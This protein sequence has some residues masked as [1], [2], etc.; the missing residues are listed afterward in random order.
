MAIGLAIAPLFTA[1]H[2]PQSLLHAENILALSP[3]YWLL[4]DIL[5][6]TYEADG[7][8]QK[9]VTTAF[10]SIGLFIVAMWLG[11]YRCTWSVPG[12]VTRLVCQEFSGI[13]YF[14]LAATAFVLSMLTFAIPCNF[15][16]IT[17]FSYLGQSRWSA[18]WVRGQLGGMGAFVDQ[19]QYFGY[20]LPS[21]TVIV[22]QLMGWL[23]RRTLLSM[24]M[25]V[26]VMAFILQ[27]GS[28]R[29]IGM[30]MGMAL[31]IWI[32]RQKQVQPRHI[33]MGAVLA[34]SI[35]FSLELMLQYRTVGL[36]VLS[37]R[38]E[39]DPL[40]EGNSI[41]VDDNF[42]RMCQ[43]IELIP[44]HYS[45]TYEKYFIW[46]VVRPIPRILWPGKPIN[47]G[48]DL[49][50]VLGFKETS[51]T[52]SVIGELYMAAGLLGV[53]LGGWLYGRLAAMTTRLL[54]EGRTFGLLIIYGT[55]TMSL[56]NGMRSMVELILMNYSTVAWIFLSWLFL[57]F[58]RSAESSVP[59]TAE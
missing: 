59:E 58:R 31:V 43:I 50:S 17:M 2:N 57:S 54:A 40:L 15:D 7:L 39:Y 49:A 52:T 4:L 47:P 34:V 51:L 26:V 53:T 37:E 48:F 8:Q 5:Q 12:R 30:M 27:S 44:E 56:F 35:L 24:C 19:L 29:I 9:E 22:A 13:T 28:R 46:I 16:L 45:Y 18:P 20:L 38:K 21:L 25:S 32:I 23:N 3:I 11:T 42:Y 55:M 6:L 14:N 36:S 10:L 1:L 33:V 41:R